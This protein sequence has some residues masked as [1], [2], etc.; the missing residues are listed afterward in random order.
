MSWGHD[1]YLYY[2]AKESSTLPEEALYIIR[3]HSFYA[4]HKE[5]AYD[6]L[7]DE[8]DRQMIP[9]LKLFNPYDLYSKTNKT[10]DYSECVPYY[11]ELISRY[12]PETVRW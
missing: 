7:L 11:Q 4:L 6:Y 10:V 9:W 2:V 12:F 5:S 1:E 3:Y 8:Y